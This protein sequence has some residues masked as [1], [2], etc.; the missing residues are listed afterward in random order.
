MNNRIFGLLFSLSCLFLFGSCHSQKSKPTENLAPSLESV[1]KLTPSKSDAKTLFELVPKE[2]SGID[3]VNRIDSDHPLSRLYISGFASGG[4]AIGDVDSDGRPDI[5]LT[6]GPDD[7]KLYRQVDDLRFEDITS[8]AGVAAESR[9]S[10]SAAMVDIENDGDLDIYVCNYDSPNQLFINDGSGKFTDHASV[11]G[12]DVADASV[13][14]HFCDYDRDGD[15]DFYLVTNRLY[16]AG[17]LPTGEVSK[18]VDG[19]RVLLDEFKRYYE[20]VQT[21]PRKYTIRTSGRPDLLFENDGKGNFQNVSMPAGINGSG[22]GLSATWFDYNLD[23]LVDLYVANDFVDPDRLYRNNGDGTFSD[24]IKEIV[25]HTPWFSMGSDS[26]DMNN[27]GMPDLMV[28]D[29]SATN[30]YKQKVTMGDMSKQQHFMDHSNPRQLMRNALFINTGVD[31]FLESAFMSGLASSD[32]S[33]AVK[34]A[35]FDNDGRNDVF[36]TNG[37]SADITNA[38]L[39]YNKSMLVGREEWQLIKGKAQ[40]I[41]PNLAFRNEG[42]LHFKNVGPDWGIDHTG[43]SYAAA[44]GDLDNDGDL[45]LVVT[46]LNE[47]VHVYRN[48]EQQGNRLTVSLRGKTNNRYGIGATVRIETKDEKQVKIV[49][50]MTGYASCNQA[51]AHFGLGDASQLSL[52]QIVWPDG[53]EQ[54]IPNLSANHH[55]VISEQGEITSEPLPKTDSS[56]MF[57]KRESLSGNEHVETPFDD[58]AIQPLLPNKLSQNGPGVAVADVDGDGDMDM[59]VSSASG[60]SPRLLRNNHDKLTA[61]PLSDDLN[62]KLTEDMAPLFFDAD[63]DGDMDLYVVAGGVEMGA[64]RSLLQDRLYLNDGSG[65]FSKAK[66]ALPELQESGSTVAAADFDR[67]GDLD[68]FVGGRL[69]PGQYP[70][71]PRSYLLRNDSTT[72]A[73]FTDVTLELG[74]DL[75]KAGMVTGALWTDVDDDGW[76]DLMVTTDW[77]PVR[78]YKNT[79]GSLQETTTQSGL[80]EFTGWW[81]GLSGRDI[82]NDGDMDYVATN[83]GLNTK[84]HPSKKK[85]SRIYYGKFAGEKQAHIVEAKVAGSQ[86][87]PVR[88]KSCSQNAMPFVREKFRTYHDFASASLTD[89]YTSAALEDSQVF[90]V[91]TLDSSILWNDGTGKFSLEP[92]PHLAQISPAFGVVATEIN[93]DG[94]PDVYLVQNFYNPQRETGKMAGGL[95]LLLLGRG[96][97]RFEEIWPSSSGLIVPDDAK[98]LSLCDWDNNGRPDFTIGV[99][100]GMTK[101]FENTIADS[102]QQ[103]CTRV[104]L[105]GAKGNPTAIGAKVTVVGHDGN[106]QT[107]EVCAGGSYLSQSTADLFFGNAAQIERI[108]VRWPNG[109]STEHDVKN[110]NTSAVIQIKQ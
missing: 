82:D 87:L 49:N 40:R 20:I 1:T 11:S 78:V 75:S 88:G 28:L 61:E 58:F 21:G 26:A 23:G 35:D 47:P 68:L 4:I 94:I 36:I 54:E 85:P 67:D 59:Y 3:F 9:W 48:N 102:S 74:S 18:R 84:Y 65:I 73:K 92:L 96:N 70:T 25:P 33:W 76:I 10:T 31:R 6:G 8:Q 30:H 108:I 62:E 77:G 41:E 45:D 50:P 97:Q 98:G 81:N 60:Q 42:N 55:Y 46:N 110:Q 53:R 106:R 14:S 79:N 22:K 93:G 72:E 38:D 91:N 83:M 24:V 2:R 101:T 52:M 56:T 63:S 27:D 95:S 7:N 80:A 100:N 13:S 109:E 105:I 5:Y 17:G 37:M 66:N 71:A 34:L 51:I 99:N 32:W 12:V 57:V 86:L 89:I 15:L 19:K 104:H 69:V 16:R 29:M 90:E 44:W 103:K 64:D 107:D 43:M 39:G